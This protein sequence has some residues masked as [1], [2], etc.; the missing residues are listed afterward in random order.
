MRADD[1]SAAVDAV[2]LSPI[3]ACGAI[4][5]VLPIIRSLIE[6]RPWYVRWALRSL[7]DALESYAAE[8]CG[9]R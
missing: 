1:V 6:G 9:S 5:V 4:R 7:A 3:E 8:R 2:D